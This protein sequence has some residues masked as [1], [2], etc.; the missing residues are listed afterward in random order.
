MVVRTSKA[1]KQAHQ[2]IAPASHRANRK[3]DRQSFHGFHQGGEKSSQYR[4]TRVH[5]YARHIDS[6][7]VSDL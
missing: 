1:V 7:R 6:L 5:P 3:D 4:G 2:G